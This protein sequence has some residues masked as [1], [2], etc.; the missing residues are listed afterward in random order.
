MNLAYRAKRVVKEALGLRQYPRRA[1]LRPEELEQQL[2]SA[3][4]RPGD[5]CFYVGANI[6][7]V[8][9]YLARVVGPE[10]AVFAFEPVIEAYRELCRNLQ[11]DGYE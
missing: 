6:G 10:G 11:G 9:L 7:D 1:P 5:T 3:L 8:S 2:Y 4:L